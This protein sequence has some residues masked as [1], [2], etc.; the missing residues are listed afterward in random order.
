[1]QINGKAAAAALVKAQAVDSG[2][3]TETW[4]PVPG[5]PG[6]RVSDMGRVQS[7]HAWR[8]NPGGEWRTIKGTTSGAGYPAVRLSHNGKARTTAIH[9]LVLLAFVGVCPDGMEAC[10]NNGDLSDNR[11]SNLRWDTPIANN[12]DKKRH[13]TDGKGERNA[14]AKLTDE[15][16]R[17]IHKLLR[18]GKLKQYEIARRVGIS[19]MAITR[20]KQGA[21]WSH[22]QI[23]DEE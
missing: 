18:E 1:M 15:Q 20:I 11:L 4:R 7:C 16:V 21:A 17:E 5:F 6:Y 19:K 3:I 13:G 10:H 14:M 8:G 9:R 22:V 2:S 23:G 12:A